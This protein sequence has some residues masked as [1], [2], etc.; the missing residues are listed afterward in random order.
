MFLALN[1]I[2]LLPLKA[3]QFLRIL[4]L[5]D[6]KP[7]W[8]ARFWRV[9]AAVG[10]GV[11]GHFKSS[12]SQSFIASTPKGGPTITWVPPGIDSGRNPR[13]TTALC[14]LAEFATSVFLQPGTPLLR[15]RRA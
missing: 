11:A 9:Y 3:L 12:V 14:F 13:G 10:V 5:V 7:G 6:Q 4:D 2:V 15:F 8:L 1:L